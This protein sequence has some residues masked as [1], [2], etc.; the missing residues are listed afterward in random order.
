MIDAAFIEAILLTTRE[1]WKETLCMASGKR[2]VCI[3]QVAKRMRRRDNGYR[4]TQTANP[5]RILLA[6]RDAC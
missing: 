6:I 4:A 2:K 5:R 1:D 3:L